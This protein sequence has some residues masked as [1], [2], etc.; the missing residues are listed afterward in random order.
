[1]SKNGDLSRVTFS[2]DTHLD[3]HFRYS[4]LLFSSL[5]TRV[6]Q[7]AS[8]LGGDGVLT[9]G[10]PNQPVSLVFEM[11]LVLAMDVTLTLTLLVV[12]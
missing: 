10:T 7:L 9:Q 3:F 8:T 4:L 2:C 6:N 5:C 11:F 12:C 1:M